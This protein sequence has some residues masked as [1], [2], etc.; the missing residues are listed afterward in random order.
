MR[1]S[2]VPPRV[3]GLCCCLSVCLSAVW[4]GC[5]A[6]PTVAKPVAASPGSAAGRRLSPWAT[7]VSAA[8]AASGRVISTAGCNAFGIFWRTG[9][10]PFPPSRETPLAQLCLLCLPCH[11]QAHETSC[12]S[13]GLFFSLGNQP[14]GTPSSGRP[15]IVHCTSTVQRQP[16]TPTASWPAGRHERTG[17]AGR[18][19]LG[20]HGHG[21]GQRIDAQTARGGRQ[22]GRGASH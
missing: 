5:T 1:L 11:P 18:R 6:S 13:A 4:C 9:W 3:P 7:T 22:G 17:R 10:P 16:E 8:M 21:T 12:R 19:P 15:R 14:W 2:S 20:S